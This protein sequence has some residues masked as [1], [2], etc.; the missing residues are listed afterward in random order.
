MLNDPMESLSLLSEFKPDLILMDMYMPGCNGMELAA[1][2]RQME[3]YLS[4][5][6]VFLSRETDVDLHF[7]A[8]KDG[9]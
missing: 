8:R 3:A 1:A 4:I 2:I 9:R 6:I 7:D 5:S